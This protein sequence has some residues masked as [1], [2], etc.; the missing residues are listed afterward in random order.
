MSASAAIP[1][2]ATWGQT[3]TLKTSWARAERAQENRAY[4]SELLWKRQPAFAAA[5]AAAEQD[6]SCPACPCKAREMITR[7]LRTSTS[8]RLGTGQAPSGILR[9]PSACTV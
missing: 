5:L 8:G 2:M 3:M 4:V 9:I 1:A 6:F 7:Q